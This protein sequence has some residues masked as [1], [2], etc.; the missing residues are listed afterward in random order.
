MAGGIIAHT[1]QTANRLYKGP[2]QL[3][4]SDPGC[5]FLLFLDRRSR[6]RRFPR[7]HSA[8][9]DRVES[10]A[11]CKVGQDSGATRWWADRS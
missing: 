9:H 3:N 4:L 7:A 10:C 8:R 6:T 2:N 11:E 1:G 5:A